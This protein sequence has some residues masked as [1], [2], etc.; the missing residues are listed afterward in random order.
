[1][2]TE[3]KGIAFWVFLLAGWLV[4]T[5]AATA[6][7]DAHAGHNVPADPHAGHMMAPVEDGSWSYTGRDNP[8]PYTQGRWE[9]VPSAKNGAQFIAADGLSARERCELL[10]DNDYMAVDRATRAACDGKRGSAPAPVPA[11]AADPH[12]GHQH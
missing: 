2:K 4:L 6:Q 11:P 8:R 9:M 3:I 10:R 7:S 5:S 12:A 1:M